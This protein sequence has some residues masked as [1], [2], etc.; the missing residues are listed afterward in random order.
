MRRPGFLGSKTWTGRE[1]NRRSQDGPD[2]DNVREKRDEP[3]PF[4]GGE[5]PATWTRVKHNVSSPGPNSSESS[6]E[7]RPGKEMDGKFC[8]GAVGATVGRR[9]APQLAPMGAN[10]GNIAPHQWPR[11]CL[12]GAEACPVIKR[13]SHQGRQ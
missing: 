8:Q 9:I 3:H 1:E 5:F 6:P 11:P 2:Q 12:A 10:G 13:L 7:V 4:V